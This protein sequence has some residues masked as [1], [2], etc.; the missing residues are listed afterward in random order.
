MLTQ[1]RLKELLIYEP[2]TGRFVWRPRPVKCKQDA[3]W[4]SAWAGGEAG[5]KKDGYF[6]ICIDYRLYRAH[7]LAFMYMLGR[8]PK[9]DVDHENRDRADNRW[10]NLR[11]ATRS[12]NLAN[13]RH[14][15][16][17]RGARK[18][19]TGNWQ[20]RISVDGQEFGLGT[21]ATKAEA[22]AAYQEA[23]TARFGDFHK[24]D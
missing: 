23:A 12:Q 6:I 21:F 20:A 17:D 8:P 4:N 5:T 3:T 10:S 1:N 16:R 22:V 14:K 11:E 19:P 2:D 13:G 18:L 24:P 15:K 9:A 7:R